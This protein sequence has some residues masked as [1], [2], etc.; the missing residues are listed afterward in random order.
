MFEAAFYVIKC[1]ALVLRGRTNLC[2]RRLVADDMTCKV[3]S[4]IADNVFGGVGSF[5]PF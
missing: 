1:R 4:V 2:R 5:S 3:L